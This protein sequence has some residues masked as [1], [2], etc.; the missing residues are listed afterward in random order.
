[1]TI[2]TLAL[3]CQFGLPGW[4]QGAADTSLAVGSIFIN[5]IFTFLKD[6]YNAND[7]NRTRHEGGESEE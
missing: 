7:F 2:T 6:S 3:P 4:V 5:E 1:M